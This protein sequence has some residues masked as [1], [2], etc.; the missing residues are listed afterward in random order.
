MQT[1][2]SASIGDQLFPVTTLT[3]SSIHFSDSIGEPGRD[4][5]AVLRLDADGFALEIPLSGSIELAPN[6]H[7]L[8]AKF[9]DAQSS[10][11]QTFLKSNDGVQLRSLAHILYTQSATPHAVKKTQMLAI[12]LTGALC[13]ALMAAIASFQIAN[14]NSLSARTAL[15]STSAPALE[16]SVAG[17]VEHLTVSGPIMV[18]E[19]YAAVRTP[20]GRT[21]FLESSA[22]GTL[23]AAIV[24]LDADIS[25]G[26]P[27]V[28]VS[29]PTDQLFVK[30]Y[31]STASAA[32]LT[33]GYRVE[34]KDTN[35]NDNWMVIADSVVAGDISRDFQFTD[36]TGNALA[37][38]TLPARGLSGLTPGQR[39]TVRFT[40]S[41]FGSF[42]FSV[43]HLG[44]NV[45]DLLGITGADT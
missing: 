43:Q 28:Y 5:S 23:Q 40:K 4:V 34:M 26:S 12:A 37:E 18:G 31:L 36:L 17:K 13:L 30:V 14:Q 3:Q 32:K 45:K 25:K 2:L 27:L 22:S 1:I 29:S 6:G 15:I 20:T 9:S 44:K 33:N 35:N 10:A 21:V 41:A 42:G 7:V 19:V 8:H 24:A 16:S 11:I 38:V 39:V